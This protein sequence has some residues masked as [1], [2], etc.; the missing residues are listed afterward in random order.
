MSGSRVGFETVS[1]HHDLH[2][3]Q[4][5][6]TTL[7]QITSVY[8][9][10]NICSISASRTRTHP[11]IKSAV[12]TSRIHSQL[13][14]KLSQPIPSTTTTTT[15]APTSPPTNM[16]FGSGQ[17]KKQYYYHE[18][19]TPARHHHHH[20]GHHHH[21]STTRV[22]YPHSPRVSTS[23]YQRSG[24]VVVEQRTTRRKYY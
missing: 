16:C 7:P 17:S 9:Q 18:E 10:H 19:L 14:C 20:H 8:H 4:T 13:Y 3:Y 15:R 2:K 1:W 5:R 24:P 6:I 12:S 11:T 23:S 22:S 21:H